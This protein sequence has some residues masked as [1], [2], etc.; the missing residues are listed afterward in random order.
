MYFINHFE[1]VSDALVISDMTSHVS[2]VRS[3]YHKVLRL[4]S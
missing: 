4:F 1:M 3:T 2:L